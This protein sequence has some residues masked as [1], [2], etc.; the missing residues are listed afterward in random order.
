VKINI[1]DVAKRSGLSVVTVSRVLNNSPTV[2]DK[3][4]EKVLQAIKELNY[5]PNSAA[6]SLASGKTGV[7]GMT[8]TTMHDWIFEGI[9]STVNRQLEGQGYFLALSIDDRMKVS[10]VQSN[11]LFQE[12]RV[13]GIILLSPMVQEQYELEL[14]QKKI[15]FVIVDSQ[16]ENQ[17]ATIV[18]VDNYHGG[19]E[20]TR[21]LIELGHKEIAHISGPELFLSARERKRGFE[22]A[23]AEA[24]LKP[25]DVIQTDFS[26]RGGFEA[27]RGW[28]QEKRVPTAVFTADDFIALG[29]IQSLQVAG[30]KVPQD[31]SVIGYD[32]QEF[33]EEIHPRLSTIRQPLEEVG[34]H[35]VKLLLG[36]LSGSSKRNTVVKLKPEIIARE[37]T[38]PYR[39]P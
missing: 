18:N 5:T 36:K 26:I 33:A 2:R 12:D 21:H 32:D 14:R 3:N 7:I 35:A 6:R 19:Y 16:H 30:Y 8:L 13:D 11:F 15:P 23:M 29:V 38:S 34:Q 10:E 4:R 31:I 28:L 20:A 24:G 39:V 1:F 27:T 22:A 17:Y 9:I 25:F 37:S